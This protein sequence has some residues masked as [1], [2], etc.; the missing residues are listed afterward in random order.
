VGVAIRPPDH[1]VSSVSSGPALGVYG[2]WSCSGHRQRRRPSLAKRF[3]RRLTKRM[4]AGTRYGTLVSI[5]SSFSLPSGTLP[6]PLVLPASF[7]LRWLAVRD[8]SARSPVASQSCNLTHTVIRQKRGERKYI[9]RVLNSWCT[10]RSHRSI[11]FCSSE[12]EAQDMPCLWQ[13]QISR[14]DNRIR[15]I[16]VNMKTQ[17]EHVGENHGLCLRGRLL[18]ARK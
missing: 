4:G 6:A 7:H 10:L 18:P 17:S 3:K 12:Q 13:T 2:R 1:T 14:Q 8:V 5:P 15:G 16:I 9:P 11:F